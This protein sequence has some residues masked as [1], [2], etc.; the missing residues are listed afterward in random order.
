MKEKG[1]TWLDGRSLKGQFTLDFR[2][3][4]FKDQQQSF[5]SEIVVVFSPWT[6]LSL[7]Q[8]YCEEFCS[9]SALIEIYRKI[10]L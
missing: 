6:Q 9:S 4:E 7:A 1:L 5:V 8:D 2:N 10:F 3:W